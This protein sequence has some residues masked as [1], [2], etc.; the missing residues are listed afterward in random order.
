MKMKKYI[1]IALLLFLGISANAQNQ[2]TN[3]YLI[4]NVNELDVIKNVYKY[5]RRPVSRPRM[6]Q[7]GVYKIGNDEFCF[8]YPIYYGHSLKLTPKQGTITQT[9]S[10]S[11][12]ASLYPTARTAAQLDLDMQP[13]IDYDYANPVPVPTGELEGNARNSRSVQYLRSFD[14]I[15]VIEHLPNGTTKVVECEITT[16]W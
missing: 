1:M 11:Q 14:K 3:L 2:G 16:S 12:I 10:I 7:C 5:L 4:F 13:A 9:I 6:Q 15:F 8:W